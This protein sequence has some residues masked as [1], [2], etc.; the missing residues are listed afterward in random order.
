MS[1]VFYGND[2]KDGEKGAMRQINKVFKDTKVNLKGSEYAVKYEFSS[3]VVTDETMVKDMMENENSHLN[4]YIR[5][6]KTGSTIREEDNTYV[7][8]TD[9]KS[10]N[11]GHWITQEITD[12]NSTTAA[13]EVTHLI[14]IDHPTHL[15]PNDISIAKD[16]ALHPRKASSVTAAFILSSSREN[17]KDISGFWD[18]VMGQERFGIGTTKSVFFNEGGYREE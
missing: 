13:H 12:E 8:E 3:E 7:S 10:R 16:K 4:N 2:A 1:L 11:S 5:V 9:L 15:P 6:E 14:G 18:R 17:R